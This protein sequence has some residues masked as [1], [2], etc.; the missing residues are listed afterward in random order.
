MDEE[1]TRVRSLPA[2]DS[3]SASPSTAVA[4]LTLL[5]HS[6]ARVLLLC[7]VWLPTMVSLPAAGPK[8]SGNSAATLVGEEVPVAHPPD[9]ASGKGGRAP[10]RRL[11]RIEYEHTLRD[12]LGLPGLAVR[13]LLPE[14]GRAY[15]FD[16]SAVALGVSHVHVAGWFA[17]AEAAIESASASH[18]IAPKPLQ[19]RFLPGEQEFFKLALLEGDAVFLKGGRYDDEALPVISQALPHRLAH[20]EQSGLFPYRH[21]VGVFRRQRIDDHFA[22]FFTRFAPI[23]AGRYRLRISVWGFQWDKGAVGP[24]PAPETVSLHANDRLLAYLDAPSLTPTVHE[25]E[26]WLNPGERLLFTA[27]SVPPARV[28]QMAGRA[29]EYT[30]PGVAIDWLDVEGPLHDTWPPESHLRLY[31]ELPLR[32]LGD[33][34]VARA[35]RREQALQRFPEA[36][37]RGE[38]PQ[39]PWGV[40]SG[41]PAA[42]AR[43]LLTGFLSRAFRRPA[44]AS[45]MS[46]AT[47]LVTRRIKQGDSFELAMRTAYQATLC[48]PGFLFVGGPPGPLDDWALAARL[49]YFLWDSMPD[50]EL[51]TLARRKQLHQPGILRGQVERMLSDDRAGRF[52]AHFTDDWLDLV[53]LEATTPD[54]VLYPEFDRSLLDAM[55]AETRAFVLEV[56]RRDEPVTALLQPGFAMINQ[57]LAR[58]YWPPDAIRTDD[59]PAERVVGAAIR[60]VPLPAESLRGGLLGQAAILKVTSNGTVTSPVKRG[61]WVLRELLDQPPDP[62]PPGVPAVDPDVRGAVSI[63]DQLARHTADSGC[64]SCH[65]AIDPPGFALENFDVLGGWRDRYR[66]LADDGPTA[67]PTAGPAVD[68]SCELPDG[69][70]CDSFAEYR[71]HLLGEPRILTR[72]LAR[73]L[74]VY[75]T[76]CDVTPADKDAIDTIVSTADEGG[77]RQLIQAIVASRLFLEQ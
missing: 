71:A 53:E 66:V 12:L 32:A 49:S 54:A 26:V 31:G 38:E 67:R 36:L 19:E 72:S 65:A 69:G 48:S 18:P 9:P 70:H 25:L 61:A 59:A 52:V 11:T 74:V 13:D 21:S 24:R 45:E 34:K 35:P 76:G 56:I 33:G 5:G 44:T 27:A 14:D 40:V 28:Y 55:R 8:E 10:L 73:H 75:A 42:D 46:V 1:P 3:M 58:H 22:L 20:Y 64:A 37:P 6:V 17:A 60:R 23:H 39:R 15:G 16:K 7:A 77:V 68:P 41:D 47:A 63:R 2:S 62:P 4:T 51:F 30:G 29:A 50:E 57:R 43:R